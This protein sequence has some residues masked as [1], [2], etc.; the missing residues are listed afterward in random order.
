M[1][2]RTHSQGNQSFKKNK[3]KRYN[4]I[5]GEK[6]LQNYVDIRGILFTCD[7]KRQNDA[8][9]EGLDLVM[10]LLED[11]TD[12]EREQFKLPDYF[13]RLKQRKNED[14]HEENKQENN[15]ENVQDN[16][17]LEEHN[18]TQIDEQSDNHAEVMTSK[19]ISEQD[20]HT[21]V[22]ASKLLQEELQQNAPCE[23]LESGV[24][25]N[26][27]I[28]IRENIN[29]AFIVTKI[30]ESFKEKNVQTRYIMKMIPITRVCH[31]KE[32]LIKENL[33]V[34]VDQAFENITGMQM[35][36]WKI[37]FQRKN[38]NSITKSEIHEWAHEYVKRWHIV[39]QKTPDI[40]IFV[41][42]VNKICVIGSV[43]NYNELHHLNINKL[44]EEVS[45]DDM[46][47]DSR[48]SVS[49]FAKQSQTQSE[50][51]N[52]VSSFDPIIVKDTPEV[53]N[54]H[55][56]TNDSI[57]T[58]NNVDIL[59]TTDQSEPLIPSTKDDLKEN[60]MKLQSKK[61]KKKKNIG[62]I[63]LL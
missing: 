46:Y 57:Q 35:K 29:P 60:E 63:R 27:F 61:Q 14:K 1:P 47:E 12:E 43:K 17:Q 42:I 20:S 25:G 52:I 59:Q 34:V 26:F 15:N 44:K 23:A 11:L 49:V 50:T 7:V 24:G 32:H 10:R 38:N 8:K 45:V 39:D 53:N 41:W 6:T 22:D 37:D 4:N 51:L 40:V 54:Q 55:L 30:V 5:R 56:N 2:K 3:R 28:R 36:R 18:N 9:R 33:K 62:G 21:Y 13:F 58:E 48:M 31:V 19:Q 16:L